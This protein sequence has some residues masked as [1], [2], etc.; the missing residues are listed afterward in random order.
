[1]IFRTLSTCCRFT[2]SARQAQEEEDYAWIPQRELTCGDGIIH[3]HPF[4]APYRQ[5]LDKI[6]N[7]GELLPSCWF[8]GAILRYLRDEQPSSFPGASRPRCSRGT[9]HRTEP[10]RALQTRA[11][12][13][14]RPAPHTPS[15][16]PFSSQSPRRL[17]HNARRQSVVPTRVLLQL[18]GACESHRRQQLLHAPAAP[19]TCSSPQLTFP[20]LLSLRAAQQCQ[21]PQKRDGGP[22]ATALL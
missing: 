20:K 5:Q 3:S 22:S 10:S 2:E 4:P 17:E 21:I 16:E 15:M 8:L 14:P 6:A 18:T 9:E 7:P 11:D 1:M 13:F 19:L 12:L